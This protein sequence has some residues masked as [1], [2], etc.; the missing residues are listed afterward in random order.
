MKSDAST[1]RRAIVAAGAIAALVAFAETTMFDSGPG[2]PA[3]TAHD[4]PRPG[5]RLAVTAT[6]Y[7]KGVLTTAGVPVRSG[8]AASDPDLLPLG[9]II[10]VHASDTRYEGIY[11]VLDTGPAV[12]GSHIDLYMWSCFDALDFGRTPV[13]VTILRLGWDPRQTAPAYLQRPPT[14][15]AA[16]ESV[17]TR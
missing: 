8:I 2:E 13:D 4:P 12:Q 14:Q 11:T 17:Q 10:Q 9:S 5:D 6:A 3:R 7:C 16:V 1:V 15:E